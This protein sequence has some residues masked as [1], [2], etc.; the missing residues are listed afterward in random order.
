MHGAACL[1]FQFSLHNA[2]RRLTPALR[3]NQVEGEPIAAKSAQ[4]GRRARA[5]RAAAEAL[6]SL[7][8]LHS[9][10][11]YQAA[12]TQIGIPGDKQCRNPV[13]GRFP[14]IRSGRQPHQSIKQKPRKGSFPTRSRQARRALGGNPGSAS[15][16]IFSRRTSSTLPGR[17]ADDCRRSDFVHGRRRLALC[18]R[19]R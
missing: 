10:L 3:R 7:L 2:D 16:R 19:S 5:P 18:G 13:Y 14:V 15:L 11:L 6:R 17:L 12:A 8:G 4:A 1:L 9:A